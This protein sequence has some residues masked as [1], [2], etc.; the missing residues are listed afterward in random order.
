MKRHLAATLPLICV[1]CALVS[2]GHPLLVLAQNGANH[3]YW[4]K[5]LKQARV[6]IEQEPKSAFWHNQAGIAYD[7]LG[8]SSRAE[9]E[10]KLA[11]N[12][13]P[14]NPV[15]YYSLYGFYQR[16]GTLSQQRT[17]LLR[18]VESDSANPLGHFEL[19]RVLEKEGYLAE[20]MSQYQAAKQLISK[21][22][23]NQ[24]VDPR[25]NPYDIGVVRNE[26]NR[27]IDKLASRLKSHAKSSK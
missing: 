6:H 17:A 3:A 10:L 25:G 18:A 8:E 9:A 16:R 23:G 15:G 12:L 20:S 7:A 5:Q 11:V 13:D 27:S 14:A 24:Y 19:A 26:V 4:E 2:I 21:I 22:Q 1:L